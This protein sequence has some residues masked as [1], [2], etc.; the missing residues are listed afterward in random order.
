VRETRKQPAIADGETRAAWYDRADDDS[1]LLRSALSARRAADSAPFSC[2][3]SRTV[4]TGSKSWGRG[5]IVVGVAERCPRRRGLAVDL[6]GSVVLGSH[7]DLDGRRREQVRAENGE[8]CLSHRISPLMR[9]LAR[10]KTASR[11]RRAFVP[12]V[13]MGPCELLRRSQSRKRRA[14]CWPE[15]FAANY[16]AGSS[17]EPLFGAG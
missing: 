10:G 1:A 8:D 2:A 16:S 7:G 17:L 3:T 13:R 4:S 9:R 15:K 12:E 11:C 5:I 6:V 14:N